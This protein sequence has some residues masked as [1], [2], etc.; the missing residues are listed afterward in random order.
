VHC[1]DAD[2]A[3]SPGRAEG[4]KQVTVEL[5]DAQEKSWSRVNYDK[6]QPIDRVRWDPRP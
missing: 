5:M 4:Q 2:G 3:V 1:V 6:R